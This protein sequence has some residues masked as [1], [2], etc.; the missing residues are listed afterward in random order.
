M[1]K[2][3]PDEIEVRYYE[4]ASGQKPFATFFNRLKGMA[5]IKI[6]ATITRLR[7]DNT[8]DSKVVG[9]GV[10]EQ[11]IG[12]PVIESIMVGMEPN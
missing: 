7:A 9:K 4:N 10:S 1:T 6:T 5:A 3:K 12:D 8:G 2:K 11:L